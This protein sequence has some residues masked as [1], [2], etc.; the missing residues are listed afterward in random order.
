MQRVIKFVAV[1][2]IAGATLTACDDDSPTVPPVGETVWSADLAAE[3]DGDLTGSIEV[4]A[5]ASAFD[6]AIELADAEAEATY[7]WYVGEGATCEDEDLRLGDAEDYEALEAD[8]EGDASAEATV[9]AT[10][11]SDEE[12]HAAVWS[13]DEEAVL[14]ACGEL[15]TED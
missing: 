11:D 1:G 6:A 13:T 8:E 15:T 12:Y 3:D 9:D 2:V 5:T 7:A 4:V 14:V 10:M